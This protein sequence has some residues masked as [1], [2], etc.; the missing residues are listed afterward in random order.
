M[1]GKVLKY[2]MKFIARFWW[3]LAVSVG[4]MSLLASAALRF[5]ITTAV[6]GD[7][8]PSFIEALVS[9]AAV[10]FLFV[11]VIAVF[12]SL[13]VTEVMVFVRFYKNFF[14]DEG[15][16]TFTLPISRK[17]LLLSK[18]LNAL[19]WYLL[20]TLLIVVC[21]CAFVMLAI[22]YEILAPL[23]KELAYTVSAAWEAL[24]AWLIVYAIE[25][26]ILFCLLCLFTLCL[27]QLCITIGAIIAKKQKVLAAVGIYYLTNM[28]ISTVG[29]IAFGI[30]FG[31]SIEGI[32]S[33]L[34]D[35]SSTRLYIS[36]SLI[37][38]IGIV[39][40]ATA[41]TTIYNMTLYRLERRLNLA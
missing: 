41:V 36:V 9:I 17:T 29:S 14:T 16:L 4:G 40:V 11:S 6:F 8:E 13:V 3:I 38:L 5:L 2:D 20:H 23:L 7:S 1:L 33:I 15:Y 32:I 30:L 27:V 12:G 28:I 22:P 24:G 31:G 34:A 10:L 25:A 37:L 35:M 19:I 26:I 18:T 39:A 21:I